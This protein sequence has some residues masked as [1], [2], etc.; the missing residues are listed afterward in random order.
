MSDQEQLTH[1][2]QN[3]SS[4]AGD[5]AQSSAPPS[6]DVIDNVL[7]DFFGSGNE[8]PVET[9]G[10]ESQQR[11]ELRTITSEEFV[12]RFRQETGQ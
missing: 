2:Q 11:P 8:L 3:L 6:Q 12:R 10:G 4:E 7:S 1:S 5:L 9:I